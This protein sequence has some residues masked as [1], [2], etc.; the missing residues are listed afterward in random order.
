MAETVPR[1]ITTEGPRPAVMC[2][3]L[4]AL[5]GIDS[6]RIPLA[7]WLEVTVRATPERRMPFR[8]CGISATRTESAGFAPP[9]EGFVVGGE[10]TGGSTLW[11]LGPRTTTCWVAVAMLAPRS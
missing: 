5:R 3:R 10:I 2:A 9:D 11:P 8:P 4:A 6:V 1:P 7:L